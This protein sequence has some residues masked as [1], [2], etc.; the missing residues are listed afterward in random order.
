MSI[1]DN[2]SNPKG[3][4]GRLM[5][6]GMNMGH[7]PMAK[8]GFSQFDIPDKANIVD[9][10]CG[11][12]YNLKRLLAACP[13]GKVFGVDISEES[14]KKSIAVNKKEVGRRCKVIQESAEKLPF[15]DQVLDLATAF[16]TV[17][18]W[19]DPQENFKEVRRV[20]KE[21]GRFFVCSVIRRFVSVFWQVRRP[22]SYL[23]E[24]LL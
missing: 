8:W 20:L 16:E 1:K 21:G 5:L 10:G 22:R 12:G 18:F 13:E 4:I 19:P 15:K 6:S 2:F 11:G 14:V 24:H 3:F 17:Y 9:I 7:S 23:Q